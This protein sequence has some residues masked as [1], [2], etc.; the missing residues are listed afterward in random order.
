MTDAQIEAAAAAIANARAGRR[1]APAISNILEVLKKLG[2]GKLYREV[3]E[4][5]R[6]ALEAAERVNAA[7]PPPPAGGKE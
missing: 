7:A 2:D 1:G 4:D 3:M 5:A 6:A